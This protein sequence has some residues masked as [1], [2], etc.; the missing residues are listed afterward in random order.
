MFLLMAQELNQGWKVYDYVAYQNYRFQVREKRWQMAAWDT[1]D[2]S[3][4]EPLQAIDMMC[5]SS[6]FYF[7]TTLLTWGNMT[8]MYGISIILRF[9]YNPFADVA[10]PMLMVGTISTL[11]FLVVVL[12]KFIRNRSNFLLSMLKRTVIWA[13]M[14]VIFISVSGLTLVK[15]FYRDNPAY[16]EAYEQLMQDPRNE[17]L[18]RK[19]EEARNNAE[20]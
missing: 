5:F 17:E 18:Q 9:E 7:M 12:I 13:L 15:V 11:I 16:I 19:A 10:L 2:E 1:L 20:H 4:A 6:Q 3:I 8:S 14:G